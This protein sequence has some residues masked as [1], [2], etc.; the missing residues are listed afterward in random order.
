MPK[1]PNPSGKFQILTETPGPHKCIACGMDATG[2]NEFVDF[3][4]SLDYVG[5][6]LICRNCCE[7]IADVVGFVP[8][9]AADEAAARIKELLDEL[10]QAH[11][12]TRK[13]DN[14]IAEYYRDKLAPDSLADLVDEPETDEADAALFE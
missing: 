8:S 3:G 9:E 2:K 12:E 1:E 13:L 6:I 14:V 7:E 5:A 10:E 11:N 4:V